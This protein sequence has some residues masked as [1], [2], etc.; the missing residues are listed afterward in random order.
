MNLRPYQRDAVE[1]ICTQLKAHDRTQVHA[2][3][4]TGKSLIALAAAD[5]LCPGETLIVVT[6]PTIAL[7]AQ[8]IATWRRHTHLDAV[9]A[10]CSD[11][12]ITDTDPDT[13][14]TLSDLR[15]ATSTDPQAIRAHLAGLSGRRLIVATYR[16]AP[17][18]GDALQHAGAS[19]DLLICDEAHHLTGTPGL[20]SRILHNQALPAA[21][22]L[23]L[24]ATPRIDLEA[25]DPTAYHSMSDEDLFGP[26]AY[27]YPFAE[28]IREGH[29][30]DYR[31][32]V[33][34]IGE[35]DLLQALNDTEHDWTTSDGTG[36]D[37]RLLAAQLACLKAVKQFGLRRVIAFASR[38]DSSKEF[39]RGLPA[40]RGLLSEAE[41]PGT[42]HA[43]HLDGTTLGPTRGRH[44]EALRHPPA[45][46]TVLSNV[47]CLSEGVDV[48]SV[49]GV[50]F[51]HAK[52]SPVDTVQAIG[53]ALRTSPTGEG[54]ATI[55]VP[56][57]I[58]AADDA[59]DITDLDPQQ[60]EVLWE[61]VNAL[62]SL[63][64]DL[65]FALDR[66]RRTYD[67]TPIELPDRITIELP[68]G[69]DIRLAERLRLL[70]VRRTTTAWQEGYNAAAAFAAAHG[71]LRVP[72]GHFESGA[73]LGNWIHYQRQRRAKGL[74]PPHRVDA[75]EDLGMVWD[76]RAHRWAVLL[77]RL[78]QF[79]TEHGHGDVPARYAF[80]D[81]YQLGSRV[82]DMRRHP[83]RIPA[84]IRTE[85][86]ALGITW[87]SQA[88]KETLLID[89][90][91]A[92]TSEHGH[93]H[94]TTRYRCEDGYPLG[95][96][97][98]QARKTW[99]RLLPTTR[100]ALEAMGIDAEPGAR[101][102]VD[103]I[104]AFTAHRTE[105]RTPVVPVRFTR[106][107]G[108]PLGSA[109]ADARRRRDDL[110]AEVA[111][112]L[113]AVGMV[114]DLDAF[115]WQTLLEHARAFHTTHGHLTVPA[116]YT[117]QDGFDLP[118]RLW[119]A[120]KHRTTVP[121]QVQHELEALGM[122][123]DVEEHRWTTFLDELEQYQAHHGD[124]LVPSDFTCD[125][126]YHLG[127]RISN[128]R[129]HPQSAPEWV[130]DRLAALG[131]IWNARQH[132]WDLLLTHLS[133]YVTEHGNAQVP[134]S[135]QCAD[136][137]RLGRALSNAR[138]RT[139]PLPDRVFD[140]LTGYGLTCRA[141]P[142]RE[143]AGPT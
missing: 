45:D 4:G 26:V 19:A 50:I 7:A 85:L 108:Y 48:P 59:T 68:A 105:H 86:D 11:D 111:A 16:S 81:G 72:A 116:D 142:R 103:L 138:N 117:S 74:L 99:E 127:K 135:Y 93:G 137:Y 114:W 76:G 35:A 119:R 43:V 122:V 54:I 42:V 88:H 87:D 109:L 34:G 25:D 77:E 140:A 13:A 136:G 41:R 30:D 83:D 31:V 106:P 121:Q 32:A 53:R 82:V 15:A 143:G 110:P 37:L 124:L 120:R 92:F 20:I 112:A 126:G 123:W 61:A 95:A 60:W 118:G 39:T 58:P 14:A 22:R 101:S 97:L 89:H 84:H 141:Q 56:I 132:Q 51:T 55:I 102:W 36:R 33:I 29:L 18:L 65:A 44:L 23:F 90:A 67:H 125:D 5:R 47:R 63:D 24:T 57:V 8:I 98:Q 27:R 73:P 80:P 104:R 78:R 40:A 49:D 96:R 62:R 9:L 1:A 38:I 3:C 91:D 64:S 134:K 115:R 128:L 70:L 107:D 52:H 133:E 79:T 46:V 10:V 75:L 71:H 94:I 113:T 21:R 129:A 69:A 130:H 28:A 66:Q 131:F 2:A 17:V 100:K 6:V 12:T 139:R